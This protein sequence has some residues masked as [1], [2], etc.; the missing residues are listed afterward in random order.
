MVSLLILGSNIPNVPKSFDHSA[1]AFSQDYDIFWTL[2][3]FR[4]FAQIPKSFKILWY[5]PCWNSFFF[6]R[7]FHKL[8]PSCFADYFKQISVHSHYT[9]QSN[10]ENLF[11]NQVQTSHY[12]L[13]SFLFFWCKTL[14]FI[15]SWC[16]ADYS[17]FQIPSKH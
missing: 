17:F 7:W 2:I 5:N 1:K 3:T 12:G 8:T 10:N 9:C 6:Y 13:R 16:K 15:A 14:E 11:V 4:T